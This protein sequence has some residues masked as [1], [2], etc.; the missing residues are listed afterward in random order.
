M[1]TDEIAKKI[2]IDAIAEIEQPSFSYKKTTERIILIYQLYTTSGNIAVSYDPLPAIKS[3]IEMCSGEG[4]FNLLVIEGVKS[5]LSNFQVHLKE[6]ML[7]SKVEALAESYS[8]LLVRVNKSRRGAG[9]QRAEITRREIVE[10]YVFQ[11]ETI[12]RKRL[13]I[14]GKQPRLTPDEEVRALE[15]VETEVEN[16]EKLKRHHDAARKAYEALC[17]S[18]NKEFQHADWRTQWMQVARQ[19]YDLPND[20]LT[21]FSSQDRYERS[22]IAIA[23][24]YIAGRYGIEASTLQREILPHA[25]RTRALHPR[26]SPLELAFNR[27]FKLHL[28]ASEFSEDGKT[29]TE[30]IEIPVDTPDE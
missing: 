14:W 26:K 12:R 22:V 15:D 19:E 16:F 10:F 11:M 13:G 3:I 8:A 4:Q 27:A 20:I 17:L 25:K 5:L 1:N 29:P 28:L 30:S 24:A 21:R 23:C 6:G 7:Q 2:L 18:R 9:V